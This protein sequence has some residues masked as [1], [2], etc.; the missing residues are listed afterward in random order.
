MRSPSAEQ[1]G[2]GEHG[3]D[4]PQPPKARSLAVDDAARASGRASGRHRRDGFTSRSTFLQDAPGRVH[5][6]KNREA[7]SFEPARRA[8]RGR[9]C[10]IIPPSMSGRARVQML[11]CRVELARRHL[12]PS[13]CSS[14]AAAIAAALPSRTSRRWRSSWPS[15]RAKLISCS[16]RPWIGSPIERKARANSSNRLG[17]PADS[18]PRYALGRRPHVIALSGSPAAYRRE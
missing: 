10:S 13:A 1:Q 14:A 9:D 17:L 7:T 16:G 5:R 15:M 18:P 8:R 11:R 3:D 4:Q 12:P 6:R 2:R